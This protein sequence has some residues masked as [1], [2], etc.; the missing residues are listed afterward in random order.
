MIRFGYKN[1]ANSIVRA[2]AMLA[3]GVVL[4]IYPHAAVDIVVKVLASFLVASGLV[5]LAYG[6]LSKSQQKES[7]SLMII[8]SAVDIILGVFIFIFAGAVGRFVMILIGI[9]L[10]LFSIFQIVV[11]ISA[12]ALVG[13]GIL[14]FALP[15][16]VALGAA[17]IIANPGFITDFLGLIAGIVLIV[18]GASELLAAWKIGKAMKEDDAKNA[19][20]IGRQ[21]I[22]DENDTEEQ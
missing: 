22:I 17:L 8:N 16:A 21:T 7:R 1:K 6:L 20:F 2:C 19:D 14:G 13:V 11:L 10:L 3:L 18:S 5:S 12:S 9:A 4:V 15:A